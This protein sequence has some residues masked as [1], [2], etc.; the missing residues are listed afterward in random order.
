MPFDELEWVR[1]CIDR[2]LT[3]NGAALALTVAVALAM[4]SVFARG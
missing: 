3:D 2:W 4:V 1:D